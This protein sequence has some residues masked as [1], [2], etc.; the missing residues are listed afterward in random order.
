MEYHYRRTLSYRARQE[1]SFPKENIFDESRVF[2]P[3]IIA[4]FAV[5]VIYA[6]LLIKRQKSGVRTMLLGISLILCGG[7]LTLSEDV[8]LG[9]FEYFI[10]LAGLIISIAGFVKPE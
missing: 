10:V 1:N 4:A 8:K 3:L 7:I 2:R 5:L 9:G 6:A